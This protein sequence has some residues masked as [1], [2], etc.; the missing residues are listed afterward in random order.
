MKNFRSMMC[1]FK[2]WMLLP[3][4]LLMSAGQASAAA[5]A[6]YTRYFIP[7][8]EDNMQR[9]F[10]EF[11]NS[12]THSHSIITVTAWSDNTT[13][14]YDHWEDGY[15]FDPDDPTTADETVVL[16]KRGDYH[17]FESAN[18]PL[19]RGT[20]T[21][22]DGRDYIYVA[23]GTTT[24][25]RASWLEPTST[26]QSV[27]WEVYPLKPQLTT[28]ILPF[29]EDLTN[30]DFDRVFTLIQATEDNTVVTVDLDG[31]GTADNLD[32]NRDGVCD[33]APEINLNAGEVFLLEDA[34]LC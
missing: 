7:G 30:T 10:S 29:G 15:D 9:I 33:A 17:T 20:A 4:L 34:T 6:G 18:I 27:A 19:P 12:D 14:Y 2:L 32:Q 28:Y 22:Y 26:T 5:S 8:D 1:I 31:D 23:G 24:V 16:A 11:G 3:L 25:S 21:Y 13:I